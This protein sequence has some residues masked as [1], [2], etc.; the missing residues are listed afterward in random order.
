[1]LFRTIAGYA[2]HPNFGG[3][4]LVGLGCEVM[5]IPALIG[6]KKL[7]S[8]GNFRYMTIQ[9]TGGTRRTVEEGVK[10]IAEIAAIANQVERKP[11]PV[12]ELIVGMQCGGSD[13][14]SGITANPALGYATDLMV[15][16]G[17][18]APTELVKP[19]DL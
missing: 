5:Q 2:Q 17:G 8:D 1:M 4:L 18:I 19:Y 10:Q 3:I 6:K 14:Y 13:G 15:R 11:A 12:S 16:H 9:H 7:R